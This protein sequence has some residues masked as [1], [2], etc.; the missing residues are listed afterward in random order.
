MI[1]KI[2]KITDKIA[3][4]DDYSY[5]YAEHIAELLAVVR[6]ELI[7]DEYKSAIEACD[8]QG[9]ISHLARYYR[10]KQRFVVKKRENSKHFNKEKA[11][12]IIEGYAR[13]VNIDWHFEENDVDFL[14]NPT[15]ENPPVNHEWL[16]QFN[17]QSYW[18]TLCDA[19]DETADEKYAEGFKKQL[20]KWIGQTFAPE[21][22][23]NPGSAWRT[24]ECGLRLLGS[25]PTAYESFKNSPSIDDVTLV[26]MIASMH[27]Q[28]VH[29]VKNVTKAN[30]LLME[31]NGVY[32]FTSLFPELTDSD[33]A[34]AFAQEKMLREIEDQILPDGMHYELSPDYHSVATSTARNLI[35]LAR[36][37]GRDSEIPESFM[38]TWERAIE[39]PIAMSTPSFTQPRTNDCFTMHT[40]SFAGYGRSVFGEKPEYEFVLSERERGYI[41]WDFTS[42]EFPYAGFV[43]MRSD[44]SADATYLCFDVGPLGKGHMHQ[45]KLNINLYKG[46]EEL[47][48][49]DGGG[50]YE[51][52]DARWYAM[53]GYD[54]NTV[55]VDGLAQKRKMPEKLDE[56]NDAHFIT[57]DDFDY[58]MGEYTDTF[59]VKFDDLSRPATWKREVAFFKPDFFAVVDTLTTADGEPHSYELLF[60]LDTTK[61]ELPCE[62]KNAL[63]GRFGKK[64]DLLLL[65][66][67][68]EGEVSLTAISGQTEPCLRGWYNGRNDKYLH[69]AL[70]VGRKVEGK[71]EFK[72]ATLIFPLAE[73]DEMPSVSRQGSLVTVNFKGAEKKFDIDAL[74]TYK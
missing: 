58:A 40:S 72:F 41:P 18:F 60:Q 69:E 56:P 31:M 45:D 30:W 68:S 11:D 4:S 29:L 73:G 62:Y 6:A 57:R 66:L 65:P 54:H 21:K 49:D 10:S 34:R 67:D 38:K 43:V 7:S 12:R 70:T 61:Y 17:R 5:K 24:I 37:F 20:L 35:L 44:W 47:L 14:F 71:K 28:S 53:S 42:K 52:S 1:E 25:W 2:K 3:A 16:W 36:T 51:E 63:I 8:L 26:I 32:T 23:N 22:H 64:Y 46:D 39:N 9:A 55:L 48:F 27:R 74:D 19:Y 13:E 15:I 59:G 50:Q 33:S